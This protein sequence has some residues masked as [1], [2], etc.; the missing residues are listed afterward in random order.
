MYEEQIFVLEGHGSTSIWNDGTKKV[1]FEWGPGSLFSPP[2]N[3]WR[4]HF[5]GSGDKPARLFGVTSVP[6]LM[7]LFRDVDF[8]F[9][10]PFSF[11]DRFDAN[12]ESFSGQGKTWMTKADRP[13]WESNFI[14]DIKTL[15]LHPHPKRGAGYNVKIEMSDN[16]MSAHVSEFP[17]GTYKKAHRHGPGAHVVIIDG[18]GYS[19]MWPVGEEPKRFDWHEGSVVV[20]P[21]DWFHQHFNTGAKPARYLALKARGHKHTRPAGGKSYNFDEDQI[22][23]KDEAP[24]I[25]KMFEDELRKNGLVSGMPPIG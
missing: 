18:Q 5:N 17:V 25:R 2:L 20:P 10:T 21:E 1:T 7:N 23:F 24:F 19:L 8:M 12:P 13:V 16:C 6:P 9:N 11:R 22:E 14:P 15:A 3:T 4:Q